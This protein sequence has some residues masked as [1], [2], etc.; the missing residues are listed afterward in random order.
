LIAHLVPCQLFLADPQKR[1]PICR[2]VSHILLSGFAAFLALWL[3]AALTYADGTPELSILPQPLTGALTELAEQSGLQLVYPSRLT[4][5]MESAGASGETPKDVLEQ[6][7]A[8]TELT[9]EYLN[10]NTIMLTE[11]AITE[12]TNT[13][14]D[15]TISKQRLS[16]FNRITALIASA[17]VATS[18]IAQNTDANTNA[19]EAQ[20]EITAPSVQGTVSDA[21]SSEFLPKAEISLKGTPYRSRSGDDGRY[22]FNEVPAGDYVLTVNYVGFEPF[23]TQ[24]TVTNSGST[25]LPITL[26][27]IYRVVEDLVVQGFRFGQSK[28]LNDQKEA[29]NIKQI[30]SEE[31]IRAFP[32]LNTAEVLQRVTGVS[33]Q[34]DMG[35]GRFVALRGT[36]SVMTN[37]TVNGQQVAYSNAENRAVELDVISAAQLSGIEVTKVITPDMD[38]DSVGGSINLKTRS[39]FDRREQ[40]FKTTIGFGENSVADGTHSRASLDYANVFGAD[41]NVGLSISFNYA[42]TAVERHGNEQKWGSEDTAAGLEIPY[43][44][45]NSEVLFS[46]NE[47][48]RYGVNGRLDFRLNDYHQMYLSAVYNYREDDQ[49]RQI[50]RI[51]WDKGDYISRTQVEGLRILKS[52]H[53]RLEEQR[54]TTYTIGGEHQ[55]GVARVDFSVSRSSAYTKKPDGQLKPEFQAKGLDLNILDIDSNSPRWDS[56]RDDIHAGSIFEFD[57]LDVKYENT[58][59]DIDS[60]AVNITIP[61]LLGSDSGEIKL[62]AKMRALEK[63]RADLRSRWKWKGSDLTVVNFESGGTRTLESG[64]NL[65]REYDRE[66]FRRFFFSNQRAN[67]FVEEVRNDVNLGEPYSA[68]EDIRG[69]YAM[70]VQNYGDLLVLAGVRAEFNQQDYTASNLVVGDDGIV[71]HSTDNVGRDFDEL[72]PNLQ[73]RYRLDENTN[74]RAAY[75]RSMARP[76]FWHAM[77]YAYTHVDDEEIVRGNPH[78][79]PAIADNIDFLV[80]H[81]FSEQV[82]VVSAGLFIKTIEDFTFRV[83]TSQMGGPFDGFD[84]EDSVNGG[85]ADLWGIELTWQQQF[86]WLPGWMSGFG[87]YANYTYTDTS[88]IDFGD[89]TGRDD[90]DVLPEQ[91]QQIGN[92]AFIYEKGPITSRLAVNFSGKWLSEVAGHADFDEWTDATTTLDFSLSYEFNN[93]LLVFLEGNNLTEEVNYLYL[94]NTTRARQHDITGRTLNTGVKWQF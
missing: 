64:Y 49:D 25:I 80:E 91:M 31:Q 27:R 94:G 70:T 33:I 75:T 20:A 29:A 73:F 77:P 36:P 32:D 48:D 51:R 23:E 39:A 84:V 5:G 1:V 87:I 24:V 42:S 37:V 19:M 38:A 59:S 9:Y 57:A 8:G 67:G 93:G 71:S 62:G 30:L 21:Q 12:G 11:K 52:L 56:S 58:S 15:A 50:T 72:F 82:G 66:A 89:S 41:E 26:N 61:M 40:L 76:N 4:E 18:V 17:L 14:Q 54:I 90:I 47:R 69:V 88:S 43:A 79:E 55:V 2:M 86:T 10:A 68:E 7:L 6:L 85:S 74:V 81:Y 63:E 45:T 34:R 44:L 3:T 22:R 78:L 60:A 92:L 28:A 65:G 13:M 53:D 46:A 35:E 83:Q 16:M